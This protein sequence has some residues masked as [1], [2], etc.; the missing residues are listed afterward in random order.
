MHKG[1]LLCVRV[2]IWQHKIYC[3]ACLHRVSYNE[4]LEQALTMRTHFTVHSGTLRYKRWLKT[5]HH[6]HDTSSAWCDVFTVIRKVPV[7]ILW[8]HWKQVIRTV[9]LDVR[10]SKLL[11][12]CHSP[13][14]AQNWPAEDAIL[15]AQCK[16]WWDDLLRLPSIPITSLHALLLVKAKA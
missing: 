13:A 3:S 9:D 16:R 1:G 6:M 14:Q 12:A 5:I 8:R 4:D 7:C 11:A 10:K 2:W 15:H